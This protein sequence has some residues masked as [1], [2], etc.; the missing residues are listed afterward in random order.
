MQVHVIVK[1]ISYHTQ[2]C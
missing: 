2:Q 1:Y